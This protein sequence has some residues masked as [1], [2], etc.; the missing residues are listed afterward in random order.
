MVHFP[1]LGNKGEASV[2]WIDLIKR[3]DIK[4]CFVAPLYLG[5]LLMFKLHHYS[6]LV[7]G[8]VFGIKHDPSVFIYG[9][10][11]SSRFFGGF[12]FGVKRKKSEYVTLHKSHHQANCADR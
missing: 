9:S 3:S 8:R 5:A 6:V 2:G 12:F 7:S 11:L 1:R 10:T 4:L